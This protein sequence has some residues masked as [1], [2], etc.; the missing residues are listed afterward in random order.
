M[1][2]IRIGLLTSLF[3]GLILGSAFAQSIP[4]NDFNC[5]SILVGKKASADGSVLF[6]HNEDDG[7]VQLV[8]YYKVP[9]I[10]H[11][12]G[13]TITLST[14]AVIPQAK[15]TNSYFWFEMP[16]MDFSDSYM[17][18]WGVV[19]ASDACGSRERNPELTD[20]GIKYW[21]RRLIA[22]RARSA[23]QGV[24]I[25]GKFIEEYGYASSGRT[26]VIAD[27]NEGWMLSAVNGKHWVAQ[28]VPDDHV[29]VLPNY[30]TIGE[31]DLAD[32]SNFLG[33]SDLIDYAVEQT[34][35]DP[36]KDGAFHFARVYSSPGNLKHLGNIQR[37]WRGMNLIAGTSFALDD[38]FPFSLKPKEKIAAQDLMKVLRDHYEGTE[39]DETK[40]YTL[41]NPYKMNRSTICA[42]ST[43][44]GFV[45][46]LRG[47]MPVEIGTLLWL[48]QFRPDSQ[49]FLPWYI[50]ISHMPDGFAYGDYRSALAEHFDPPENIHDKTRPH[51]FW[52]FVTLA[53]KVDENYGTSIKVVQKKWGDLEKDI[54]KEQSKFDIKALKVYKYN[55][56]EAKKLLTEFTNGW[57]LKAK[58]MADELKSSL[59]Q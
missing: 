25:G 24:K 30:Y 14:G 15:V 6:A 31:I 40:G 49:A 38:E 2:I 9:R 21:L 10:E 47:W 51:A 34:W 18:E 26:Y 48:A 32:T 33:S 29:A 1:R 46:Q 11:E 20:G 57:A 4:E 59:E 19:I 58:K 54:F 56:D 23:K 17:N 37:K 44:Y 53:E 13:E 41:G 52:S 35:Y 50:G 36:G 28:R 42:S 45:A 7:G 27:A 22:E 8:N 3:I 55:P 43:Q 12:P 39:L 16:G 5:F